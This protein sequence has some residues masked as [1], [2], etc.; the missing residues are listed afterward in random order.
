MFLV[1]DERANARIQGVQFGS[2]YGMQGSGTQGLS[3]LQISD[4]V[5]PVWLEPRCCPCLAARRR[6]KAG[7]PTYLSKFRPSTKLMRSSNSSSSNLSF[8]SGSIQSATSYRDA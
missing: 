8:S 3:K 1:P 7:A 5:I 4:L 2:S 6:R